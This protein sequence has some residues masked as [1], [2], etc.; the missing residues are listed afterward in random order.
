MAQSVNMVQIMQRNIYAI[1]SVPLI[2]IKS[3]SYAK[4]HRVHKKQKKVFQL[5][6]PISML[7]YDFTVT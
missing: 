3:N 5:S 1:M 4:S 2:N 7:A 6:L